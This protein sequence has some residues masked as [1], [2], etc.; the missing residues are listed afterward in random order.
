MALGIVRSLQLLATLVI[1]VPVAL[2]G[3]FTILDGRFLLG[4]VFLGLAVG[5]IAVSEYVYTRLT[6]RTVGRLKRLKNVR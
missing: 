1:A 5:L 6:D 3:V 4:A 2:V